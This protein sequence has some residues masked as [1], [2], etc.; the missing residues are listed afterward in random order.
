MF[1]PV[2]EHYCEGC[3]YQMRSTIVRDVCTRWGALLC[4]MFVP[5]GEHYCEG[6]LYQMGSTIVR[7]VCTRWGALL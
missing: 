7:D 6:C 1:V 3:L 2:G 4:G 5:D